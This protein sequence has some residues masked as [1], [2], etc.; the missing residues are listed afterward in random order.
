MGG[1]NVI[2]HGTVSVSQDVPVQMRDGTTLHADVYSPE[3]A[4]P[5]PVLLMRTPY[6]KTQAQDSVYAHPRWY[7]GRAWMRLTTP[8]RSARSTFSIFMAS[9]TA[10]ASPALTS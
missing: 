1:P 9:T 6:N 3:G 4:G 7:A 8:S 5:F 10:S 2:R